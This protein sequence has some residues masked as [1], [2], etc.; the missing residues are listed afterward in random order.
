[1]FVESWRGTVLESRHRVHVAVV[2]ASGKLVAQASDADYRTFWRSAAK[3]FQALPLVED[4]VVERFG[5]RRQD[6]ALACASHSSE[7]AQVALVR[8]FLQRVGCSERDLMCG[9]HR[10]LS[11]GVAKHYE[12]RGVRLTAVS[13]NCSG[14]H[15]GMLALAKHHGWPTKF[16][17]RSEHPVQQRCLA[18]ISEY[19]DV[20]TKEVGVAVDGCGVACFALPLRNMAL[21]YA[22]LRIG[23]GEVKSAIRNPQSAIV[24]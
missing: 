12:T 11:D 20:A 13:S 10:P 5:L 6:L 17:A 15:T 21:G 24:E 1:L 16:Y 3:P 14:K 9:P 4:G 2:D 23:Q 19:T 7:P 18:A 8:E 22:R